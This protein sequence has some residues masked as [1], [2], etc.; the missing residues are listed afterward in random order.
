M[1]KDEARRTACRSSHPVSCIEDVAGLAHPG[2]SVSARSR[3]SCERPPP[4][5]LQ[6]ERSPHP[7]AGSGLVTAPSPRSM[8]RGFSPGG[9]DRSLVV[10]RPPPPATKNTPRAFQLEYRYLREH[11]RGFSLCLE[12]RRR[13]PH[14]RVTAPVRDPQSHTEPRTNSTALRIGMAQG[15]AFLPEEEDTSRRRSLH[16]QERVWRPT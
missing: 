11:A 8:R 7:D 14:R 16:H 9:A 13:R 4:A 1:S 10:S 2:S 15:R 5:R 6:R 3:T 12:H